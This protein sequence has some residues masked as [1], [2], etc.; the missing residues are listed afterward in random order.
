[1]AV[2]EAVVGRTYPAIAPYAVGREKIREFATAIKASDALHFDVAA[3]RNAGYP[4]LV[5]P[6][7]F[8]IIVSQRADAAL[9]EDPGAGIDFSRVVHADQRFTHHRPIVAGDELTAAVTVDAV[10][11]LGSGA[12]VTSRVEVTTVAGEKVATTVSSLLVRGEDQ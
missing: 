6:P 8:A 12:M 1:M 5:A 3:A 11:P 2:S 4:D 7:T 9:V 10:R